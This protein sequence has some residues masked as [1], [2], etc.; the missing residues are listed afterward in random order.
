MNNNRNQ[1]T[2]KLAQLDY[3]DLPEVA[4]M[5][6]AFPFCKS[7]KVGNLLYPV[8]ANDNLMHFIAFEE[9]L[10]AAAR[11]VKLNAV[12]PSGSEHGIVKKVCDMFIKHPSF[13]NIIC[14]DL[15]QGIYAPEEIASDPVFKAK[16]KT[17]PRGFEYTVNQMV[18][19]MIMDFVDVSLVGDCLMAFTW[20]ETRNPGVS[21][22]IDEVDQILAKAP[23]YW[24]SF[25]LKSFLENIP[26]ERLAQKI[27]IMFQDNHVADLVCK[28]IGLNEPATDGHDQTKHVGIPEDS[29]LAS[30]LAY[31][32]YLPELDQEIRR[33]GFTHI[34]YN[35]EF[36]VFCKTYA[37][38]EQIRGT[39]VDYAKNV[40]N[41]PVDHN[42]TR[43]K[44]IGHLAFLGLRLQGGKWRIQY[45]VKTQATR[46]YVDAAIAY[47]DFSDNSQLWNAYW[48]LT[49]FIN[50]YEGVYDL[51]NEI[52]NLKKWRDEIFTD[53]IAQ[54]ERIKLGLE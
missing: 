30:L 5:K 40:M 13:G 4:L 26:H 10:V 32:L 15:M 22:M 11:K 17:F 7:A 43:I 51:E 39:L 38:A 54:A 47:T 12:N 29:P 8:I 35:D 49:G 42:R 46:D 25:S 37:G 44:D 20:N 21:A 50:F 3:Q 34:R 27:R 53:A 16:Y 2:S 48:K 31:D 33:H 45:N 36:V 9:N 19:T 1:N 23:K 28:L 41:C 52:K 14:Q 6:N 18:Q 24:V